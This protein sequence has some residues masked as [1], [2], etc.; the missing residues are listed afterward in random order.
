MI[1]YFVAT[2]ATVATGR[3]DRASDE[4]LVL[5]I[6]NGIRPEINEKIVPKYYI[7]LRHL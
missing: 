5:N 1:M 3:Q 2:V 6:R 7:E 4:G